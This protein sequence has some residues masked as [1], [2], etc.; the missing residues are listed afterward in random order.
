MGRVLE[1]KYPLPCAN[2]WVCVWGEGLIGVGGE[3]FRTLIAD[4]RNQNE[5]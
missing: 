3:S 1:R 4:N 2:L 5:V